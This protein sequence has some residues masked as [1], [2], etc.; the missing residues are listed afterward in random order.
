MRRLADHLFVVLVAFWIGALWVVGYVVAPTL[1]AMLPDRVLAG[2]VAGRLFT[3]VAWIG[4][5]AAGYL[6]LYLAARLGWGAFRN[7]MFWIVLILLACTVAGQFGIQPLMAELKSSAWPRDVMNSVMRDRFATWHGVS[8]VLYLAQSL[9]GIMLVT[10]V[11]RVL[12]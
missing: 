2:N 5:G 8:S 4:M 6:L 10:G 7:G 12:R 11:N 1:F 3:L 9:L